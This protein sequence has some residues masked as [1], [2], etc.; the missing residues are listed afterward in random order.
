MKRNIAA[1]VAMVAF[2]VALSALEA[3]E[4]RMKIVL[5][6]STGRFSLYYLSDIAKSRYVA[7]FLDQDPRT[8]VT[9][10]LIDGKAVRLGD[11]PS[12]RVSAQRT[13][14]GAAFTFRS[15]QLVVVQSFIF[16]RSPG[17]AIVDG[18]RMTY[19]IENV[20]DRDLNVGLRI[21]IDTSLGEGATNHFS[22]DLKPGISSELGLSGAFAETY[23]MSAQSEYGLLAIIQGEGIRKPDS[24]VFANWKRL[25]DS[26]WGFEA[27]STRNFNLLPYSINDSAVLML[28]SPSR[29]ARGVSSSYTFYLAER[30]A[31]RFGESSARADPGAASAPVASG[32]TALA[33]VQTDLVAARDAITRINKLLNEG[34][35]EAEI[36]ELRKIID[37]LKARKDAY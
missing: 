31:I 12:F 10:I 28:Y 35:T 9:S 15:S 24:V 4:G 8:S 22:T 13:E 11:D 20:S 7:L 1:L 29:L 37:L 3:S 33:N 6:E 17:S 14:D 18:I 27:N 16:A 5:H 25:N 19:S 30:S 26:S 21:L 2:T 23:W 34:A 36:A 32:V